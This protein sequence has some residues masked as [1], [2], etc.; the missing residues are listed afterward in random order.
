M[1]NKDLIYCSTC[2]LMSVHLTPPP[3]PC[4]PT[5]LLVHGSCYNQT[6]VLVWSVAKGALVYEVTATG[7]L[8]YVTSVQTNKTT[9][10]TELLC[11]QLFTFTVKAQDNTCDSAP[12][13]PTSFK[14]GLTLTDISA[15]YI[16]QQVHNH[17]VVHLLL[18]P[19]H[20]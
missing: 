15:L 3:G 12:S 1:S 16:R 18:R 4:Q 6:V 13:L 8:G 2:V 19:L 7:D 11:G 10:Q 20:P 9:V 17:S 14:T 5:G